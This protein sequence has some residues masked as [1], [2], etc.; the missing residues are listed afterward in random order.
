MVR[1]RQ[2]VVA[3]LAIPIG[4]H[5]REVVAVAPQRVRVQV[6]LVPAGGSRRIRLVARQRSADE[7]A[8]DQCEDHHSEG[9]ALTGH[10]RTGWML[11][12][13]TKKDFQL[14]ADPHPNLSLEGEGLSAEV[15]FRSRRRSYF[16]FTPRGGRSPW[17]GDWMITGRSAGCTPT[18][19]KT[20]G[21]KSQSA[22]ETSRRKKIAPGVLGLNRRIAG[23]I[24]R[25]IAGRIARP[26]DIRGTGAAR[27][28]RCPLFRVRLAADG[29]GAPA[30]SP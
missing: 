23:R 3:R 26:Q 11:K 15:I 1:N 24:A 16:P 12:E 18:R 17:I 19:K 21:A 4:D 28:S 2:E 29:C 8:D 22:Q 5:L 20:A 25:R 14:L 13:R 6:A 27:D 9:A 10:A 7:K 30:L